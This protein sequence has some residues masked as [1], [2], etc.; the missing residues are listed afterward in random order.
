MIKLVDRKKKVTLTNNVELLDFLPSSGLREKS[1]AIVP[2]LKL[3]SLPVDFLE[4]EP[5]P[6]LFD[7][8]IPVDILRFALFSARAS[9]PAG[10]TVG[11]LSLFGFPVF[12]S[13]VV[14][15]GLSWIVS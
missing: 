8:K 15:S 9:G 7:W 11:V 5:E 13:V 4:I 3:R 2:H 6:L 14:G 1:L 12:G 10:P